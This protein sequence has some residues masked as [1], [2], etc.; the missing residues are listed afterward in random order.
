[1]PDAFTSRRTETIH[2]HHVDCMTP[3]KKKLPKTVHT[4]DAV[5]ILARLPHVQLHVDLSGAFYSRT[6]VARYQ[7]LQH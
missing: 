6:Q 4:L 2:R 5:K 7:T 1:M 3:R